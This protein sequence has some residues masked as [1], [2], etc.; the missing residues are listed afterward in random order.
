MTPDQNKETKQG[1]AELSTT[2]PAPERTGFAYGSLFF[3]TLS[4]LAALLLNMT[5]FGTIMGG[6]GIGYALVAHSSQRRI[7]V[8]V[9]AIISLVGLFANLSIAGIL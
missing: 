6:M 2:R 7:L 3:G 9:G 8:I 5:T 1:P 4:L